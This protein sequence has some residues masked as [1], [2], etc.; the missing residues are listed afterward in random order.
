LVVALATIGVAAAALLLAVLPAA[1]ALRV[2][3]LPVGLYE[4]GLG[5]LGVAVGG[6]KFI[7]MA[8][9]VGGRLSA[10]HPAGPA[11]AATPD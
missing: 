4:A 2:L 9:A 1:V 6:V 7:A 11:I 5:F 3:S 10:A 8:C